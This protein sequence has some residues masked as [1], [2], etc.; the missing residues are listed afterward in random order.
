LD[1]NL[2]LLAA[3]YNIKGME[4]LVEQARKWDN[5]MLVTD[6]NV[7]NNNRFFEHRTDAA[8]NPQGQIYVQVQQLIKTAGKRGKEIDLAKINVTIAELQFK[9]VMRNLRAELHRNFYTIVQLLGNAQLYTESM[10][11]L[12]KLLAGLEQ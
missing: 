3:H 6:Q 10:V 4:A 11:R 8:G 2:Q 9:T 5:P 1:S 12:K 7:Y